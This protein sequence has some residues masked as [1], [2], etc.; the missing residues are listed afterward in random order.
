[1]GQKTIFTASLFWVLAA[2]FVSS[3]LPSTFNRPNLR[4]FESERDG[5]QQLPP[6]IPL[7]VPVSTLRMPSDENE[8]KC[9]MMSSDETTTTTKADEE[10]QLKECTNS[11]SPAPITTLMRSFRVVTIGVGTPRWHFIYYFPK[12]RLL[13]TDLNSL[14]LMILKYVKAF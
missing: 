12:I 13:R 9:L 6:T 5:N 14:C 11:S 7:R 3:A 1:M 8:L 10:L 4:W 2:F